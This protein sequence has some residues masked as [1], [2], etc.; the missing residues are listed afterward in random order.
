[1]L[2]GRTNRRSFYGRR[3]GVAGCGAGATAWTN[4][5]YRRAHEYT[6]R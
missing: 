5:A 4:A 1:M 2:V 3:G 6:R